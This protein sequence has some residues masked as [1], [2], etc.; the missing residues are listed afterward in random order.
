MSIFLSV[1]I[2]LCILSFST[3]FMYIM[4]LLNASASV[5]EFIFFLSFHLFCIS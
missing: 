1:G 2:Y 3:T 5:N 4:Y